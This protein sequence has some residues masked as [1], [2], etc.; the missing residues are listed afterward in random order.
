MTALL[1]ALAVVLHAFSGAMTLWLARGRHGR[2]G[3]A[4]LTGAI[5]LSGIHACVQFVRVYLSLA[6]EDPA[7]AVS[8]VGIGGLLAL[9][10]ARLRPVLVKVQR[11]AHQHQLAEHRFRTF[12]EH[13]PVGVALTEV[14]DGRTQIVEHNPALAEV[15]GL[16]G[17]GAIS[18]DALA[19]PAEL[20]QD[21]ARLAQV[22]SSQRGPVSHEHRYILAD[23]RVAWGLVTA[24]AMRDASGKVTHTVSAVQDITERKRA[25][26]ALREER[27]RANTVLDVAE[28]LLI[29]TDTQGTMLTANRKAAAVLGR[30]LDQL[31]GHKW[32]E[33]GFSESSRRMAEDVLLAL[34]DGETTV[35]PAFEG[36]LAAPD[37]STRVIAWRCAAVRDD[38]GSIVGAMCSGIDVTGR[39]EAITRFR[40]ERERVASIMQTSPIAVLV[41]DRKGRM[42]YANE[43]AEQQFGIPVDTMGESLVEQAEWTIVDWGG[44]PVPFEDLPF[45]RV[46]RGG[47]ALRGG[48]YGLL[49]PDGRQVQVLV[50][51]TRLSEEEHGLSGIVCTLQDVSDALELGAKARRSERMDAIRRLAAGAAHDFNNVLTAIVGTAEIGLSVSPEGTAAAH[52]ETILHSALAAAELTNRLQS[53]G[54]LKPLSP[55]PLRFEELADAARAAAKAAD[56]RGGLVDALPAEMDLRVAADR[57]ALEVVIASL[58]R[59][60]REA[61]GPKGTVQ[62][63]TRMV[64]LQASDEYAAGSY[65]EVAITNSGTPLSAD[66]RERMFE[67]YFSTQAGRPGLGLSE[68]LSVVS[69][70]EGHFDVQVEPATRIAF[71][72]PT[73]TVAETPVPAP[74]RDRP[75]LPRGTETVLVVEDEQEVEFL[76]RMLLERQGYVVHTATTVADAREIAR[77]GTAFDL[78][79]TDVQL[80]DGDGTDLAKEVRALRPALPVLFTS[81]LGNDAV[82]IT[83][84]DTPYT[85]FVAKPFTVHGIAASVRAALDA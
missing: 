25:E 44:K 37:G 28:V 58:L 34:V 30:P 1:L 85:R 62:L 49:Y 18:I 22:L 79:L 63:R 64:E 39:A 45:T 24:A 14:G 47:D 38:A 11:L 74:R 32:L 27:D 29:S 23:G 69:R 19:H 31:I 15:L 43:E 26:E 20:E 81:G 50:N 8:L 4:L 72:L 57:T 53:V 3:W 33:L 52:F 40:H 5:F 21:A 73:E 83:K 6:P 60:A 42:V 10:I 16:K 56:E 35:S 78:L 84:G 82:A 7:V 13:L 41:I 48:R 66:V 12:F 76:L 46:L 59:N 75:A 70:L 55:V 67:P 9:A 17:T 2:A 36:T 65:V 80:P 68:A 71:R 77:N 51:I 61:A 54:S